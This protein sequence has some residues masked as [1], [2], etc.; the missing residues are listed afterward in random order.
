MICARCRGTGR[1]PTDAP[2]DPAAILAD[3][4]AACVGNGVTVLPGERVRADDA[5]RLIDRAPRTLENWRSAGI[6][7][8][9]NRGS[10][11]T[12]DL[13]RLAAHIAAERAK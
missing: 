4:R 12:Y 2:D 3:L 9:W 11:V 10:R 7:P 13:S 8:D 6:G 1:E 5:G